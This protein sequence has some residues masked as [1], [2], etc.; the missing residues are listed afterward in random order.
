[1]TELLLIRH[2]E[3]PWNR[4]RRIQGRSDPAVDDPT[5][6]RWR[7]PADFVGAVAFVSPLLRARQTASALGLEPLHVVAALTEMDWGDWEGAK[8]ATLRVSEGKSM[9]ENEARG[10]DF[11][12]P[13]GESPREL[14]ARLRHWLTHALPPVE[15]AVIVSHKGL[16]RA[17]LSLAVDWDFQ[18]RS[19]TRLPNG[20][21]L[22]M[23]WDADQAALEWL[24][25]QD[26]RGCEEKADL[27]R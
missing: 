14:R 5:L 6:G 17:A 27:V 12:P 23:R 13:R 21:A 8:I 7:L 19:P 24:G 10:L 11:R 25:H 15:R 16:L 1:M 18:G 26:L 4:E 9:A 2:A 20:V 3:T 22:A